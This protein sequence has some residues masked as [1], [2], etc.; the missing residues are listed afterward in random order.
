MYLKTF[1]S[2]YLVLLDFLRSFL[3][4]PPKSKKYI[5][6]KTLF[7]FVKQFLRLQHI[8]LGNIQDLRELQYPK[9]S[10]KS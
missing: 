4:S 8:I 9:T 3:R 5:F 10:E 2:L 6:C 1:R 7:N